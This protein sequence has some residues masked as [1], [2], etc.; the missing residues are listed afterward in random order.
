[1]INPRR[2][3]SLDT[4]LTSR[5][6]RLSGHFTRNPTV[7][8]RRLGKWELGK[9]S[10][11]IVEFQHLGDGKSHQECGDIPFV[12]NTKWHGSTVADRRANARVCHAVSSSSTFITTAIM[13]GT[14]SLPVFQRT[15]PTGWWVVA[16]DREKFGVTRHRVPNDRIMRG[17]SVC[18]CGAPA[19]HDQM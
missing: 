7:G 9:E 11:P 5:V 16:A 12:S 6:E 1:M 2:S 14:A 10:M 19:N 13:T 8:K 3:K 4:N 17:G 15:P 18:G